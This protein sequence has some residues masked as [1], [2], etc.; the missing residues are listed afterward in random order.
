MVLFFI[1]FSWSWSVFYELF[2]LEEIIAT[3]SSAK[4][5]L[6]TGTSYVN[7]F[8]DTGEE[9]YR[10]GKRALDLGQEVFGS[11]RHKEST[12]DSGVE[13]QD[14]FVEGTS[15]SVTV[16]PGSMNSIGPQA[17][18]DKNGSTGLASGEKFANPDPGSLVVSYTVPGEIG[19]HVGACTAIYLALN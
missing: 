10:T 17:N 18:L 13:S 5:L 2:N 7:S 19:L 14:T 15:G 12:Q 16:G 4:D 3:A 8:I 1:F 11:K 9:V 6:D